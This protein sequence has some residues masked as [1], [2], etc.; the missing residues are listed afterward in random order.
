[1]TLRITAL[2]FAATLSMALSFSLPAA[3]GSASKDIA[4]ADIL[5]GWRS[6]TGE[7]VAALRIRLK[8]GWKTYWRAPGDAGV[9]PVL[10]WSRSGNL[11]SARIT[12]P[13]PTVFTQSG[14]RSIGYMNEVILPLALHPKRD[15]RP[16][17]LRGTLDIGVCNEICV[18][19]RLKVKATL[20][21]EA[22]QRDP[23]IAAALAA[24]PFSASEAGLRDIRCRI[25]PTSKGLGLSLEIDMPSAGAPEAAVVEAG[26]PG[27]WV[28]EPK[29]RRAGGTLFAETTMQH[30]SGQSFMLDRSALRVTVIGTKHAV[31]IRGCDRR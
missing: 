25:S 17:K 10:D 5:T 1:M 14:M 22:G 31:D 8:D 12:W 7:H 23:R 21:A 3:A 26:L 24:R 13:T 18:P 4:E 19:Q 9:P 30:V 2:S 27:V 15:D 20:P 6:D 28:A 29:T 16:V 11:A